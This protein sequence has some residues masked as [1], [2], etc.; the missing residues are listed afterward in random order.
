MT[1]AS[2]LSSLAGTGFPPSSPSIYHVTSIEIQSAVHVSGKDASW[3]LD[4]VVR[5]QERSITRASTSHAV[6]DTSVLFIRKISPL[7]GPRQTWLASQQMHSIFVPGSSVS[8]KVF[9]TL[10]SW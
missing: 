1:F 2:H 10:L 5:A 4:S 7:G 9:F 6:I 3:M 8:V